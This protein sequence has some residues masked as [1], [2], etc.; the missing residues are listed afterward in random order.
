L[1]RAGERPLE[2]IYWPMPQIASETVYWITLRTAGEPLAVAG[3]AREQLR[4][5]DR[6]MPFFQA[7]PLSAAVESS[8]LQPRY[9]TALIAFF[10]ALALLL[11]AVGLYGNI[12]YSVSQRRHEIGIRI[13]LGAGK[14]RVLRQFLR[15][16]LVMGLAGVVTGLVFAKVASSIMRSLV[17]GAKVDEPLAFAFS[18]A[19]SISVALLA[20]YLPAR[21]ATRIDP[22]NALRND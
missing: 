15:G 18:A 9:N 14:D 7:A 2:V 16:G 5:M 11:T 22:M 12:A 13:A 20:T 21:R 19:V 10:A 17:F 1:R 8:F 3:A 4:R 6:N